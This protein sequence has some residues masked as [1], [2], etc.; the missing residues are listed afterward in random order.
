MRSPAKLE[1]EHIHVATAFVTGGLGLA[2]ASSDTCDGHDHMCLRRLLL[3]HGRV[4]QTSASTCY[5]TAYT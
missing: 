3:T 1:Y 4:V 2:E 5:T